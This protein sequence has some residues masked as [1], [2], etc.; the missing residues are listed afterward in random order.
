M[1]WIA[2]IGAGLCEVLGVIALRRVSL[3]RAWDPTSFGLFA[4]FEFP[5]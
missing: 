2:L 5:R 1:E 4:R 3:S